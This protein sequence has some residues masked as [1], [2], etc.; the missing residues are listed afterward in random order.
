MSKVNL[1]KYA[2]ASNRTAV[3]C[4]KHTHICVQY[5]SIHKSD[6]PFTCANNNTVI[7]STG[8]K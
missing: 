2:V 4:I 6:C 3:T 5:K 1:H 7:Y 8:A